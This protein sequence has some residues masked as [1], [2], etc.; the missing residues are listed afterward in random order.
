M[1]PGLTATGVVGCHVPGAVWSAVVMVCGRWMGGHLEMLMS[2]RV[3][4]GSCCVDVSLVRARASRQGGSGCGW[5]GVLVWVL[6][7]V[8]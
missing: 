1:G 8:C 4:T 3:W 5:F 2:M 7:R 6:V